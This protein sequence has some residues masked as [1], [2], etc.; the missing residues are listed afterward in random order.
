MTLLLS[1]LSYRL[2][3]VGDFTRSLLTFDKRNAE[4]QDTWWQ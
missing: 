4:E 3:E 2:S 1:P